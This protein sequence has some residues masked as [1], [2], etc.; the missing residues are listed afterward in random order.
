MQECYGEDRRKW[1]HFLAMEGLIQ[2]RPFLEDEIQ[3]ALEKIQECEMELKYGCIGTNY[4][5]RDF[6]IS[7]RETKSKQERIIMRKCE[8]EEK[9]KGLIASKRKIDGLLEHLSDPQRKIIELRY[10]EGKTLKEIEAEVYMSK[11]SIR[12]EIFRVLSNI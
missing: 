3:D 6:S 2:S 7:S 10:I 1:N 5:L 12:R 4:V 11:D 8:L 9:L